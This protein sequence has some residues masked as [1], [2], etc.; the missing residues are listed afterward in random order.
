MANLH[1]AAYHIA[2]RAQIVLSLAR[3]RVPADAKAGFSF[4]E[5][6]SMA[7]YGGRLD[8]LIVTKLDAE[9]KALLAKEAERDQSSLSVVTRRAIQMYLAQRQAQLPE[10]RNA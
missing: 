7:S 4:L 1:N 9:T 10:V 5:V 8:Q 2:I 3:F 6:L